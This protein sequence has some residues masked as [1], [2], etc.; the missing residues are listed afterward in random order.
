[1]YSTAPTD[2]AQLIGGVVQDKSKEFYCL[3]K[4]RS[5]IIT[6]V[7]EKYIL[8]GLIIIL[9]EYL[10]YPV[11]CRN[12]I[13]THYVVSCTGEFVNEDGYTWFLQ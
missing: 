5:N 7:S 11:P 8:P 9:D 13:F 4:N 6:A 12:L 2:W 3:V 1:M 10:S